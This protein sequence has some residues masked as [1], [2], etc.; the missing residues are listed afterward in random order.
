LLKKQAFFMGN[1]KIFEFDYFLKSV[2]NTLKSKPK[3]AIF[4]V[5]IG[6]NGKFLILMQK[7]EINFFKG[8]LN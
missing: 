6:I 8:T 5:K 4:M 7:W 3:N 1:I 2:K